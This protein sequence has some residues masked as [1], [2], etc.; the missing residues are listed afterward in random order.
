MQIPR[1]AQWTI[2]ALILVVIVP[3]VGTALLGGT[4]ARCV[5][6]DAAGEVVKASGEECDHLDK[7]VI[8]EPGDDG[9]VQLSGDEMIEFGP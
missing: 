3:V 2:T 8:L 1:W 6:V 9:Q 4:Q 7:V 5:G